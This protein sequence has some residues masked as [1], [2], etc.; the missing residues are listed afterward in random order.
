[1]RVGVVFPTIEI[2]GD[3][4]AIRDWARSVK[5]LGY[6]RIWLYEHVLRFTE[7][8]D[9]QAAHDGDKFK[10]RCPHDRSRLANASRT[11]RSIAAAETADCQV[12]GGSANRT[13]RGCRAHGR[14]TGRLTRRKTVRRTL[15]R[16][17]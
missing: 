13:R 3:A 2:G 4:V 14:S 12:T 7:N 8:P 15:S 1:M 11:R 10:T 16:L 17:S 5:E 6:D 9:R